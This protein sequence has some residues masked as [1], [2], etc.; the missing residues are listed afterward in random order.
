MECWE[1]AGD[2]LRAERSREGS[3]YGAM[4]T[5]YITEGKI[6]PMEVTIKASHF[7][8]TQHMPFPCSLLPR[9]TCPHSSLRTP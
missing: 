7:F 6:V 9:L 4:I 2:L 8:K 3:M 1:T 5:E